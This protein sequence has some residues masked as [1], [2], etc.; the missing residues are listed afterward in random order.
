MGLKPA[1]F[2]TLCAVL[3]AIVASPARSQVPWYRHYQRGLELE[4]QGNWE[5]ALR[6]IDEAARVERRPHRR[7]P[8]GDGRVIF[9]YDPHYHAARCLA[10]LGRYPL[11]VVRLRAAYRAGVTPRPTLDE[12]RARIERE[13]EDKLSGSAEPAPTPVTRLVVRGEPPGMRVI[14]DG[15]ALGTAPLGPL[16]IAPG[17]HHVRLEAAGRRA[18]ERTI[19]VDPGTT[20]ELAASLLAAP[21]R[22]P[23]SRTAGQAPPAATA[24]SPGMRGEAAPVPPPAATAIVPRSPPVSAAGARRAAAR[25]LRPAVLAFLLV[26]LAVVVAGAVLLNRKAR[27]RP[28]APPAPQ[29]EPTPTVL[30]AAGRL[31]QYELTGVLGRGGMATTYRAVRSS[32]GTAVAV[33]VPHESCLADSTFLARFV[34]EGNLGE[35]LHHPRIVRIFEAGEAGGRP[36]LAMELLEGRTLKDELRRSAPLPLDRALAITTDI[37]EALDYAHAKGVIHRDL[38]PENVMLLPDGTLRV[39]DFGIARLVDQEGIT[40]SQFFLGTPLYSAP[41]MIEPRRIDHRADLYSLGII[42]FE[43]LDGTVPF[44]ADSPLKVLQ[45]HQHDPLPDR[46]ALAQPIPEAVWQVVQ[47]LCAKQPAERFA[48]AQS[49]LVELHALLRRFH[50]RGESGG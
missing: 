33:K 36:F 47:R 45:M 23:G 6:E 21:T 35:Q 42:L 19:E 1:R 7:V 31:G 9:D 48:S 3:L 32:D 49:L 50:R 5:D 28:T 27:R 37:A 43:M 4:R 24:P 41:E 10:E 2:L 8:A 46:H 13:V 38:K 34:R 22:I 29:P 18:E 39:M 44:A 16:P 20:Y 14:V 25:P 30:S 12:L 11:A 15:A 17:E 40:S 26:V